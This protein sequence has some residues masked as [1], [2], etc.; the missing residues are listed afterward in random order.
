M[1]D[2]AATA[3]EERVA[4]EIKLAEIFASTAERVLL[5]FVS[6]PK[7]RMC[8][9]WMLRARLASTPTARFGS[10]PRAAIDAARLPSFDMARFDSLDI[11]N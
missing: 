4:S 10:P 2:S 3:L 9:A 5:I 7:A 6:T 8:S 1:V 11:A